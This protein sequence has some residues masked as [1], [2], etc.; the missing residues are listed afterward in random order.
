MKLEHAVQVAA[1]RERVW[2]FLMD[3]P[4]M[5][6]CIPGASDVAQIDERTF[7]ATVTAK[8]G[9]VSA[10]FGCR[11]VVLELDEAAGSGHIE[12]VGKDMKLGGGIKATMRMQL[13]EDGA[14]T[15]IDILSDVDIMGRIGQYGHGIITKR[16]DAMLD[17]F[18]ACAQAKLA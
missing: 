17:A 6:A 9:P 16:A 8:I 3:V 11:I 7:D 4:A 15:A 10:K 2:A 1:P 13:R 18:S 14:G 12:V 5:A